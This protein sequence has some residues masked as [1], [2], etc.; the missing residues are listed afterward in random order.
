M[1]QEHVRL[2]VAAGDDAELVVLPG[3]GHFDLTRPGSAA[4]RQVVEWLGR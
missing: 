4:W 1:S 3:A 2:A